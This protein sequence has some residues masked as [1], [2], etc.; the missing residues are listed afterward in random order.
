[1][2]MGRLVERGLAVPARVEGLEDEVVV[3][4]EALEKRFK[5]SRTTLL[6]PFDSLIWHRRRTEELF[7]YTV[8]FEVYV[9]RAKRRYGYYNLPILYRDELVGCLDPKVDRK[10]GLLTINSLPLEP[11]FCGRDDDR[12]YTDLAE[13]LHDFRDFNGATEIA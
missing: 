13:T 11:T 10:T 3:W 4:A 12:F 6:S 7:D 9:P 2:L 5:P 8:P 1:E